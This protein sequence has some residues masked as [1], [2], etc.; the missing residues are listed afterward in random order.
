MGVILLKK[1]VGHFYNHD[2]YPVVLYLDDIDEIFRMF[3]E[4]NP[5][6]RIETEEYEF[7]SIEKLKQNKEE[8]L[9][10]LEF[11]I[12]DYPTVVRLKFDKNH[13]NF[14]SDEESIEIKG[15]LYN[16]QLGGLYN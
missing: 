9:S 12:D 1:K 14:F 11:I 16:I 7:N 5:K 4:F 13:I 6:V 3:S 2:F 10:Y 8:K 15:L